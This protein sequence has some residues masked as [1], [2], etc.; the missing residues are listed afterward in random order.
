MRRENFLIQLSFQFEI[1]A[2]SVPIFLPHHV[3]I[4]SQHH[5]FINTMERTTTAASPP[6]SSPSIP[7]QTQF[8][9]FRVN[10]FIAL[11]YKDGEFIVPAAIMVDLFD[12]KQELKTIMCLPIALIG[13][14][15]F[16]L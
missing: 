15:I 2:S 11:G 6:H 4:P 10:P 5:L 13:L 16:G 1:F 14:V 7:T 3:S 12:I 8:P 9:R